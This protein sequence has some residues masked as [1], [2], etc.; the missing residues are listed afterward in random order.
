MTATVT[1][2]GAG[3]GNSSLASLVCNGPGPRRDSDGLG[4]NPGQGPARRRAVRSQAAQAASLRVAAPPG[5][6]R[7][8]ADRCHGASAKPDSPDTESSSSPAREHDG[9]TGKESTIT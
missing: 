4:T 7:T 8:P 1:V 5:L 2:T 3:G 9:G 6:T